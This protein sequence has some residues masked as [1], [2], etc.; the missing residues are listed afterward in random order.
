[1]FEIPLCMNPSSQLMY[2]SGYMYGT[3]RRATWAAHGDYLL[4][5]SSTRTS[6]QSGTAGRA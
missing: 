5:L 2:S 6:C 4:V 1:M 3:G